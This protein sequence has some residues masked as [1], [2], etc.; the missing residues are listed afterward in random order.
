MLSIA[1]TLLVAAAATAL[2]LVA[3]PAPS[4]A[5]ASAAPVAADPD[6]DARGEV[7]R[8]LAAPEAGS[9]TLYSL[10]GKLS[11][12]LRLEGD[13]VL[14]GFVVLGKA[15]LS[16][17]AGAATSPSSLSPAARACNAFGELLAPTR[18]L[19]A[20]CFIPR[21][22]LTLRHGGHRYDILI[23]F[24]CSRYSVFRDNKEFLAD[25][26]AGTPAA[27]DS[28]NALL[29]A[30]GVRLPPQPPKAE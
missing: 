17:K 1:A 16:D 5:S 7:I 23:C 14:Q 24:E 15:A 28:L 8:A 12:P 13:D 25:A 22:A 11:K 21:H 9:V 30:A 27:L 29:R 19:A 2:S 20:E 26:T 3:L 4:A 18:V 6:A 10:T